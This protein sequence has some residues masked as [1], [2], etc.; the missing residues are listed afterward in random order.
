[1]RGLKPTTYS[2]TVARWLPV[3]WRIRATVTRRVRRSKRR[4]RSLRRQGLPQH[5]R[6]LRVQLL[7]AK[8]RRIA[9]MARIMLWR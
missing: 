8:K 9:A 5:L 1:M 2:S 3:W 4:V 7:R 6:V